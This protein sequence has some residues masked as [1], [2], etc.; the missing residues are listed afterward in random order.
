MIPLFPEL[1]P[2][3][4][5]AFELAPDGAE[6]SVDEKYRQAAMGAGGW[7]N[8][9]LRTTFTKIIKRAGLSIWPRLFHNLWASRET[10][11]VETFPLQVVASWLRNTP[12]IALQHYL[13]VT[14]EHFATAVERDDFKAAQ[15]PAQ[16]SLVNVRTRSHVETS[17]NEK[18]PV[19]PGYA[20]DCDFVQS[21]EVEC[22]GL[23][24]ARL[25]W[26][27]KPP[28]FSPV[29]LYHLPVQRRDPAL[30]RR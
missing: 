5:E 19:L 29:S 20:N 7:A 6:Y 30:R 3:L 18:T 28:A 12:K 11:L 26:P 10:E 22:K 17:K 27:S 24:R 13:M 16:R 9:N 4:T 15:N 1:R 2:V 8:A 21:Q 25:A 14:D 23:E